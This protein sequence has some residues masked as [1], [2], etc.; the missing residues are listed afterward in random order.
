MGGGR[1]ERGT[2]A[3]I[4]VRVECQSLRTCVCVVS[5]VC[6]Y[7]CMFDFACVCVCVCVCVRVYVCVCA[8][9]HVRASVCV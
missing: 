8:C 5:S 7:V 3:D 2:C 4:S 6:M 9:L 1:G